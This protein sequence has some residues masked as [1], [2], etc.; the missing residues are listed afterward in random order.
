MSTA[1]ERIMRGRGD[2]DCRHEPFLYD[3]YVARRVRPLPHFDPDPDRPARYE[4]IRDDLLKAAERR[5]VFFKDMSYYVV[6]RLFDDPDFATGMV[7]VFLIR[8]PRRSILSYHRLDPGLTREEVGLE[9][10]ARHVAWLRKRA[11]ETPLVIEAEAVQCDPAGTMCGFWARVGLP[12]KP[13]ALDWT[14]E[15]VPEDWSGVAGWHAAVTESGGIRPPESERRTAEAF[16]AA[17]A[18]EPRLAELLAWH[19]PYYRQLQALA[20]RAAASPGHTMRTMP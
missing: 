6:P 16:A 11:G 1:F 2:C 14:D 10:Q 17:A 5:P 19:A 13:E 15:P 8:D 18:A 9:A 4:E 7:N 12:P 3:Y 20:R